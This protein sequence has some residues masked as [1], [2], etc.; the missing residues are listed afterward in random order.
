[1]AEP[2]ST[3]QLLDNAVWHA[4]RGPLSRFVASHSTPELLHFDREVNI[5]SGVD[6]V[7][8]P[9]IAELVGVG[10][11][12]GLFRGE[13]PDP[14]PGWEVHYQG[15]GW[16]MVAGEL[17]EPAGL[18]VVELGPADREEMLALVQLTEPAPFFLRTAEL[19]RYIGIRRD[20]RLLAMAGERLRVPGYVE[21]SAVC[22][23]PDARGQGLAGELTLNAARSIRGGG[24]EAFLHVV[25]DNHDAKRLYH[26]LGF[27]VRRKVDVL[28]ARWHGPDWRP[29]DGEPAA[30]S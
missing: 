17:V 18:D 15:P 3:E 1:M 19:G 11:Y 13:I 7:D 5:F 30:A 24:A 6:Q 29:G 16:Q 21:I 4:L 8:W 20:G 26:K 14:P 28:F 10:E 12:C 9:R 22:T 27:D 23:H 25:A 2:T